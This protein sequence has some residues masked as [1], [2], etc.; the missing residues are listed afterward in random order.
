MSA[1]QYDRRAFMTYFAGIGLGSTLLPGVLWAATTSGAEITA[2]TIAAA[3]ELAGLTFDESERAMMVDG[4][5]RNQSRIDALHK[6]ALN[7]LD[8]GTQRLMALNQRPECVL[9]ARAVQLAFEKTFA[10]PI[11]F[12]CEE[13]NVSC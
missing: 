12:K 2:A 11:F 7:L 3:E 13:Y 8:H 5:K 9:Y 6:V 1:T 4:L 10:R